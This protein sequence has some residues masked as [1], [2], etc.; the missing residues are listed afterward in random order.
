MEEAEGRRPEAEGREVKQMKSS[1]PP[2]PPPPAR[3]KCFL[4]RIRRAMGRAQAE[5]R[6]RAAC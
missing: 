6:E 3:S 4:R 2:P 1:V 5:M